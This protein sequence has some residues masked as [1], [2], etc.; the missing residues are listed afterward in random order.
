MEAAE[1][2]VSDR[3]SSDK[4]H[5]ASLQGKGWMWPEAK[6]SHQLEIRVV[7]LARGPRETTKCLWIVRE[8]ETRSSGLVRSPEA[9]A[10]R[11][12]H[13]AR[14]QE[15]EGPSCIPPEM[16]KVLRPPSSPLPVVI[17]RRNLV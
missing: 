4:G 2:L 16:V 6:Q 1:R 15:T 12:S 14:W 17:R 10:W 7:T 13:T 5:L 11:V 3:A 8:N 9:Q